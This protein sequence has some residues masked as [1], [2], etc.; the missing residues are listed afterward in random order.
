ME[1]KIG[2]QQLLP[3]LVAWYVRLA[4][5]SVATISPDEE[6]SL[7]LEILAIK[8]YIFFI[9]QNW[10]WTRWSDSSSCFLSI[11]TRPC[12]S[13][14]L[15]VN[16]WFRKNPIE[17]QRLWFNHLDFQISSSCKPRGFD[18]IV[19]PLWDNDDVI[20]YSAKDNTFIYCW[21]TGL[22]WPLIT[23]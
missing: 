9:I 5:L 4:S 15:L 12:R 18:W 20:G 10:I 21:V 16:D 23:I 17:F 1:G 13:R 22:I 19:V 7:S 2:S 11:F 8:Y 6:V 14:K 3:S